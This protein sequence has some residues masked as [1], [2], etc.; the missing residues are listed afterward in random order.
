MHSADRQ[1]HNDGTLGTLRVWRGS[2]PHSNSAHKHSHTQPEHCQR[3]TSHTCAHFSTHCKQTWV[4]EDEREWHL[5]AWHHQPGSRDIRWVMEHSRAR[6]TWQRRSWR[7]LLLMI[8]FCLSRG[9]LPSVCL[10]NE[11][12]GTCAEIQMHIWL[13]L[14]SNTCTS[15]LFRFMTVCVFRTFSRSVFSDI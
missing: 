4:T 2:R 6:R 13:W 11:G 7:I 9:L 10:L 15:L 8:G 14:R 3:H 12:T 5:V 1:P